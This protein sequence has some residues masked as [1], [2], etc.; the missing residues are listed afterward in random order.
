M[1][2][3]QYKI[4]GRRIFAGTMHAI[5]GR[6]DQFCIVHSFALG[7]GNIVYRKAISGHL[8]EYQVG[9]CSVFVNIMKF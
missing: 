6:D 5:Q 9:T 3:G 2:T 7:Q 1:C 4:L 8:N